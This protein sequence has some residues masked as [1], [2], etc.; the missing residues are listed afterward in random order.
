[1]RSAMKYILVTALVS[2]GAVALG[3]DRPAGSAIE[4]LDAQMDQIAKNA[5]KFRGTIFLF[6]QSITPDTIDHSSQQSA[7]PSYQW[8]F[9]VRPRYYI[10]RNVSLRLRM[11][12]TVDWTNG[13]SETTLQREAQFG[14]I[15]LD[16]A[17]NPPSFGGIIPTVAL[18]TVWGTSKEALASGNVASIGP[19]ASL[20]REF[21][22]K[23][24]GS[25][26]LSLSMYGLYHFVTR[27][28]P[29]LVGGKSYFCQD[30]GGRNTVCDLVDSPNNTQFNLTTFISAKYQPVSQFSIA[31]S[32]AV[33]DGWAYGNPDAHEQMFGNV[34]PHA[35]DDTRFRQSGWFIA[36]VDYEPKDWITLSLGYYCLR[37]ILDPNGQYGNPFYKP[38]GNSRIYLTTT[39]NIDRVYDAAARRQQRNR[40]AAQAAAEASA[41]KSTN[42]AWWRH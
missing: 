19:T 40:Q 36:N 17:Y 27:E 34:V 29:G 30:I 20:V 24:A 25:F 2:T 37:G 7:V 1:M 6:D 11:D 4:T 3:Q 18:R 33:L 15:W 10:K 22:T 21:Q 38:G 31:L 41:V 35:A 13:G 42:L 23:K 26:E 14:D 5:A 39:F 9:S 16:V 12:L 28:Q 8:W 32:Y